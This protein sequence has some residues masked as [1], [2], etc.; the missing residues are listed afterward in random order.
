MAARKT[1]E[2]REVGLLEWA[3]GALGLL[4]TLAVFAV[5]GYEA[6]TFEDGPP[7]LVVRVID[8]SRNAGGHVVRFEARNLGST[9]AAEVVVR[10]RLTEGGRPIEEAEATLDYV[11]RRS[12]HEAGMIF[13][14]DPASV[15]IDVAAVSYRKP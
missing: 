4:I 5:L 2:T 14:R 9:T 15:Q 3:A 6:A 8:I 7:I 11:A 12:R 10:A 1:G 13:Q